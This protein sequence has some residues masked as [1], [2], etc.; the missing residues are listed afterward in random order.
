MKK[1]TTL[2]TLATFVFLLSSCK[3]EADSIKVHNNFVEKS[4]TDKLEPN[5]LNIDHRVRAMT[6]LSYPI[7]Q[8]LQG[9]NFQIEDETRASWDLFLQSLIFSSKIKTSF[10]TSVDPKKNITEIVMVVQSAGESRD[11]SYK[12]IVPLK[13]ELAKI[14]LEMEK[15]KAE[16]TPSDL[17]STICFYSKRPTG[18]KPFECK[19]VADETYS[20]EK[21]ADNCRDFLRLKFLDIDQAPTIQEQQTK[22]A[23]VQAELD[24][25]KETS[26]SVDQKIAD[27][28]L[29]R[30]AG[31]SVVIDLL[32]SIERH[33]S[34]LVL[35]A[36]GATLE[37][38]KDPSEAVSEVVIEKDNTLSTFKL[39]I[40]F[41]PNL[42]SGSGKVE[43]SREAG[44]IKNLTFEKE[45]DGV[46][47]LRFD[48][49]TSDFV[50]KTNL[51]YSN[52]ATLG[53][54][55]V[56]DAHFHYPNGL[57]RKGVMKLEFDHL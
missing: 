43:Y 47:T 57:I 16:K 11:Q 39:I 55:F 23:E 6:L 50:I 24:T 1:I 13:K 10:D 54:R 8:D 51:S 9:W 44:N 31:E 37:K 40:D 45:S 38:N 20:K 26:L 12:K 42:S 33:K 22:C 56:G 4:I 17:E 5:E 52:H 46:W 29:I 30:S 15:V 7:S 14:D 53:M 27:E 32:Q 36:T 19:T 41:G 48:L 2:I 49:I 34:N 28:M 3:R 21:T 25:L 18:T 35:I